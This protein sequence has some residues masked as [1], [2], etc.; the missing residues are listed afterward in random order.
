MLHEYAVE[1]QAIGTNWQTFRYIIEKFGFDRGRLISEF[2]EH[3]SREVYRAAE[4]LTP[5]EKKRIEVGLAQAQGRKVV[6][7]G[8]HYNPGLDGWLANALVEHRRVPFHAIIAAA[9]QEGADYVLCVNALDEQHVLMAVP[10]ERAVL[11][12]VKP[13]SEA[14][15]GLLR[16]GSR[17][18]FVDP[19]FSPYNAR[20][21]RL[22]SQCFRIVRAL[23][24]KASLEIHYRYHEDRLSNEELERDAAAIFKDMIPDGMPVTF[25][26]WSERGDGEDFHARY[27]LTEKGGIRVDAGFEPVGAHQHTDVTLMDLGL[28]HSH[29]VSFSRDSTTYE[30]VEPVIKVSRDGTVE[31]V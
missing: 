6:Y 13:L 2:P 20:Y 3:W 4:G 14:F 15:T 11:R 24:G 22:F 16:F 5:L 28:A 8:R 9:P 25:Y 12:E 21:R 7:F 26:C 31:H 19:L 10:I 30:L 18:V 27:L 23:N 29:L 17:I 1:P